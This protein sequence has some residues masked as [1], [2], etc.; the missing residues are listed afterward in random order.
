ML[1]QHKGSRLPT[2]FSSLRK[3]IRLNVALGGLVWWLATLPMARG[4][5][6]HDHC[7][8]F[9]TRPFCDSVI[10]MWYFGMLNLYA[11]ALH[12]LLPLVALG[13]PEDTPQHPLHG[14]SQTLVCQELC[15]SAFPRCLWSSSLPILSPAPAATSG[16]ALVGHVLGARALQGTNAC[17][18][19]GF[20]RGG[21]KAQ[22]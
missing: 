5:K 14:L 6:L 12:C 20:N 1:K 4:L 19:E 16:L 7:V 17:Q 22:I 21:A 10:N 18:E 2:P 9:Q 11:H 8:P 15:P 13:P 3:S